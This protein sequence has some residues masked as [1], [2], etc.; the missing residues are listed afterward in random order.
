MLK[1]GRLYVDFLN[2]N[3]PDN[4]ADAYRLDRRS[5]SNF[6]LNLKRFKLNQK[7]QT[8]ITR[9]LAAQNLGRVVWL[10]RPLA[11]RLG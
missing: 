8:G 5:A 2:V 6:F 1:I 9:S 3:F 7:Y 11:G 4:S 10:A